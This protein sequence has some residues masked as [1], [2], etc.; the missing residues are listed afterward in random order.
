MVQPKKTEIP[1]PRPRMCSGKISA[2][3]HPH[4]VAAIGGILALRNMDRLDRR[5]T[6]RSSADASCAAMASIAAMEIRCCSAMMCRANTSLERRWKYK[7]P[8]RHP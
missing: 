2:S 3:P 4:V 5:K 8:L 6:F 7:A 1:I